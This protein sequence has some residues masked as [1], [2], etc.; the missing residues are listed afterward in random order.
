MKSKEDG[1]LGELRAST[2]ESH[3]QLEAVALFGA[4]ESGDASREAYCGFL[5]VMALLHAALHRAMR[6]EGDDALRELAESS[7]LRGGKARQD[8]EALGAKSLRNVASLREALLGAEDILWTSLRDPGDVVGALYVIQ[9]SRHGA[10]SLRTLVSKRFGQDLPMAFWTAGTE[11]LS[12]DWKRLVNALEKCEPSVSE[13]ACA[14]ACRLFD[15]LRRATE[16]L[17]PEPA[18]SAPATA[19]INVEAGSHAV[20]TEPRLL[21]ASVMAGLRCWRA[22][23]YF[24]ARYGDRGRR[25]S[26]SDSAWLATLVEESEIVVAG[27]VDWLGRVL[28]SRGMPTQLLEVHL[29]LLHE[30]LAAIGEADASGR[31]ALLIAAGGLKTAGPS[32]STKL[33]W[34]SSAACS[35]HDSTETRRCPTFRCLSL[36]RLRTNVRVLTW[37]LPA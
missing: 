30:E 5:N 23:P 7:G 29:G 28:A 33:L 26:S 25:F 22:Y 16:A 34:M 20:V 9:G 37:R 36:L 32:I 10:R 35:V 27:Q 21:V 31:N 19:V 17:Y 13:G 18:E 1:L 12:E 11:G 3:Q 24:E 14:L 8:L 2:R 6:D 15:C 4:L